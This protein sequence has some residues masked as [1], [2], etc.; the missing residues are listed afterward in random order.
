MPSVYSFETSNRTVA[1]ALSRFLKLNG[2]QYERSGCY[3]GYHFS[4]NA[5]PAE[6]DRIDGYLD[7]VQLAGA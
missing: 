6:A 1:D 2:V 7:S 4:I 5:T 3:C